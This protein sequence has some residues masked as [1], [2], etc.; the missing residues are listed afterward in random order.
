[1]SS[2]KVVSI[3]ADWSANGKIKLMDFESDPRF[4]KLCKILTRGTFSLKNKNTSKSEDLNT[5]LS[6]TAEDEAAKLVAGITLPQM[7]KV[8]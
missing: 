6:I 4:L 7:V 2:L 3:L 8:C 1:M 5:I